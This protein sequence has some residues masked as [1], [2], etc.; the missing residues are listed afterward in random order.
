MGGGLTHQGCGEAVHG[1][2]ELGQGVHKGALPAA[3]A[4]E[5]A[6]GLAGSQGWP[7]RAWAPVA[8]SSG[9]AVGNGG[10]SHQRV[11]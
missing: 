9:L 7:L 3:G 2:C 10:G 1:L 6:A 4:R 5:G 8:G 11:T